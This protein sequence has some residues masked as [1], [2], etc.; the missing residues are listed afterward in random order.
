MTYATRKYHS[1]GLLNFCA[2]Y[3]AQVEN[4]VQN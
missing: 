1:D 4:A 2:K 3:E